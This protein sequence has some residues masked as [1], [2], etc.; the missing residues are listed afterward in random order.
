MN[1]MSARTIAALHDAVEDPAVVDR[2]WSFVSPLVTERGCRLWTGAVSS[3]GHGR[4]W[5]AS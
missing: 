3:K 2:Y 4:L 1:Q 5:L